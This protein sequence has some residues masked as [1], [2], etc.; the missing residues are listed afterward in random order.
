MRS[1]IEVMI[2]A[3]SP[4]SKFVFPGPPGKSVSPVKSIGVP[5][6]AKQMLPGV[7]PGRVQRAQAQVAH[8]VDGVVLEQVVVARQHPGVLG[9]HPHVDAGVADLFDGADV[10]PV[11]VGLEHRG[12]AES[13][14]DPQQPVVLVGRVEQRGLAGS[15]AA[16]HVDVVLDGSDD[17][18]V[19]LGQR[20]RPDQFDV[21]HAPVCH[22]ADPVSRLS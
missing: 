8:L 18:S 20:V 2:V 11:A 4:P 9:A 19:H 15:P 16:H 14:R 21:V 3:K 13:A 7:W 22:S 17:E 6:S 10:V 5:S 12:D 1:S